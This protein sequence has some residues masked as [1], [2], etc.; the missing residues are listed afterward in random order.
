[1]TATAPMVEWWVEARSNTG[2]R[3]WIV[4][5]KARTSEDAQDL[6]RKWARGCGYPGLQQCDAL[7]AWRA[8]G[9]SKTKSA[10]DKA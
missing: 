8:S 6:A 5:F 7:T 9:I 3:L 1:M 2:K 10:E 4:G